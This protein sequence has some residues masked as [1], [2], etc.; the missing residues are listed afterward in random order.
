MSPRSDLDERREF[1]LSAE[2]IDIHSHRSPTADDAVNDFLCI[3]GISRLIFGM[4]RG[5]IK[6]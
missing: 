3:S 6:L 4:G 5:I 1:M 2:D